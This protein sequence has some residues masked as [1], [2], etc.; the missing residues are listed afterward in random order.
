[1]TSSQ[2]RVEQRVCELI[3][4]REVALLDD[5]RL[6]VSIPTGGG[7][8]PAI[9]ETRERIVPAARTN[10]LPD[11]LDAI[12]EHQREQAIKWV[13]LQYVALPGVNMDQEHIDA[14]GREL[15]GIRYIL[16]VIPWN[17]TGDAPGAAS[18]SAAFRA[19]DWDEV[20][21]FT[22]KLRALHCPVKVRYS[23]GK[24]EG[25]GCGQLAAETLAVAPSGH[26]LAPPGI[27]TA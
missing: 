25:M 24:R 9:Q 11:L 7:N 18:G 6:H 26:M 10:P 23:A 2:S 15:Q 14:L 13:T 16:N 19:P 22:A 20:R 1:M 21:A 4:G 27:F 17:E 3:A 8:E 12:R 5:L